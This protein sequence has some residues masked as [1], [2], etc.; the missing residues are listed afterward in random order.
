[1]AAGISAAATRI[2]GTKGKLTLENKVTAVRRIAAITAA[3][4]RIL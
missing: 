4:I 2:T 1:M 3:V